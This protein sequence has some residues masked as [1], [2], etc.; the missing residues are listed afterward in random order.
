[1]LHELREDAAHHARDLLDQAHQRGLAPAEQVGVAH[2]APQD[3]AQHVAAPLVRGIDAVGQEERDGPRVVGQDAE[4]RAGRALVVR[5]AHD[6][7]GARD[8]RREEI[9][10][11][12]GADALEHR[13]D[14][15][16]PGARV[17]R[18]RGQRHELARGLPVELHEDEVPDLEE[19]PRLGVLDELIERVDVVGGAACS[20]SMCPSSG[21]EVDV[22]LAARTAGAG[23]GHLPEV[24]RVAETVDAVVPDTG[25][26][27]P[28]APGVVVLGVDTDPDAIGMDS[29]PL[30]AGHELP[31]E[32]DGVLLEVVAEGKVAEHLEEGVVPVG[33]AHLLEVVV[34]PAGPHAL[35]GGGRPPVVAPLQPL[36]DALELHHP[37]VGEQQSRVVPGHER[38]RGHLAVASLDEE[39]EETAANP[40]GIHRSR[41]KLA[42]DCRLH[43]LDDVCDREPAT[44]QVD[45]ELAAPRHRVEAVQRPELLRRGLPEQVHR[46]DAL[47]LERSLDRLAGLA[48]ADAEPLQVAGQ[49]AP[50]RSGTAARECGR[51]GG[52][53]RGR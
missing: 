36:E 18:R 11:E 21:P 17:H 13:G 50:A 47:Q 9:G 25:H 7:L 45:L 29:E 42:P 49:A 12:V 37:G 24:V 3:P 32:G 28:E 5:L 23:V 20:R 52:R 2:G 4:R 38:R 22:H 6:R 41:T 43:H 53:T 46:F 33:V 10:V 39:V 48:L 31:G 1:M 16:E 34:L 35:L 15:L 44:Q 19:P 30:R 40:C 51:S 14:A 8:Q 27:A 26:L